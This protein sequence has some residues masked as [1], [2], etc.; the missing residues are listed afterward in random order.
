MKAAFIVTIEGEWHHNDKPVTA[1]IMEKELRIAAKECFEHLAS[2]VTVKSIPLAASPATQ[3]EAD[4]C[5]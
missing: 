2:R 1:R 5:D 3:Q 4:K